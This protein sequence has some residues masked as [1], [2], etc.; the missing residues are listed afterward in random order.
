MNRTGLYARVSTTNHSQD[1]EVQLRDM[2]AYSSSRNWEVVQEYVDSGISGTKERRPALDRLMEDVRA[3]K[4]DIVV[5]ARWD[6]FARSTKHLI[7]AVEEFKSRNVQFVSV[8]EQIDTTTPAGKMVFTVIAAVAELERALIVERV[9]AGL[10]NARA[11]GRIGG[12]PRTA[13]TPEDVAKAV[14]KFGKI[15]RAAHHLGISYG[16]AWNLYRRGAVP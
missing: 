10:R 7:A 2:R 15:T 3:G 6:R 11:N 16:T 5:V 4:L 9:N 12:R 13:V 8:S 1:P 14:K